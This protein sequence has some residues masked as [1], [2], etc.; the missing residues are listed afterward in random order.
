MAGIWRASIKKSCHSFSTKNPTILSNKSKRT[1]PSL[2]KEKNP[3]F[4][5][6]CGKF[7]FVFLGPKGAS[8]A[9][10]VIRGKPECRK[11]LILAPLSHTLLYSHVQFVIRAPKNMIFLSTKKLNAQ[12]MVGAWETK[13]IILFGF[14]P[15]FFFLFPCR[16]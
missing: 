5:R 13:I 3:V 12:R 6:K 16:R 2:Q 11:F 8:S 7:V 14:A 15:R 9:S 1:Y 4:G 10:Y